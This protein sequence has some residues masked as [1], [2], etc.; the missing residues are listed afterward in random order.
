M[1]WYSGDFREYVPVGQRI[2]EAQNYAATIA[3]K[4]KR[5]T[6][7]VTI[8]GRK[9]ATTF[10]GQAWCDN[11][12]AYSDYSNRLPRG[13]TYVRNGSVVDLVIRPRRIEA[14]VAGSDVYTVAI[15]I[16]GLKAA[17]WNSIKRDCTTAI[18]SLLELLAG[19]FSDSVMQR[20]TR[21]DGGLFPTPKEIDMSCSCPDR[22]YC[23]KHLAAAMYGVGSR[24][25]DQPELLFTLRNVDPQELVSTAVADGSLDR[26][27]GAGDASLQDQD[28]EAIFGIDLDLMAVEPAGRASVPSR[29]PRRGTSSTLKKP[30]APKARKSAVKKAA[31]AGRTAAGKGVKSAKVVT[32][33]TSQ[34]PTP[35]LAVN[36]KSATAGKKSGKTVRSHSSAKAKRP[37]RRPR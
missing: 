27:L 23:C 17:T 18:D 3:R 7:P 26:Q 35:K 4:Q 6:A 24:L 25:D 21:Q 19:R 12:L 34:K 31:S 33:K 11:L 37:L 9:I 10:W 5:T 30:V 1:N 32:S 15:D 8:H 14:I 13:A 20:L 22:S 36:K 28:L 29:A 2:A 16:V